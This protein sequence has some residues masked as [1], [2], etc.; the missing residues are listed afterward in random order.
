MRYSLG[1]SVIAMAA[2]LMLSAGCGTTG[3]GGQDPAASATG[4]WSTATSASAAPT[5]IPSSASTASTS[6]SSSTPVS[7]ASATASADPS[8][9]GRTDCGSR[10]G[11]GEAI[12]WTQGGVPCDEGMRVLDEFI[13]SPNTQRGD[14]GGTVGQYECQ[15]MGAGE[16]AQY[17]YH[18]RCVTADGAGV[19][20]GTA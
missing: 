4:K 13:A 10:P 11:G 9:T 12:T 7:S 5:S 17:S 15:I 3:S 2:A 18:L 14:K 20:E 8:S 16:A 1:A 19:Y 6:A